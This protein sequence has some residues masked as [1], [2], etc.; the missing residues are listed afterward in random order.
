MVR[1][2][3]LTSFFVFFVCCVFLLGTM[4]SH[5]FNATCDRINDNIEDMKWH[6]EIIHQ[7]LP[8][9]YPQNPIVQAPCVE[10]FPEEVATQLVSKTCPPLKDMCDVINESQVSEGFK[11]VGQ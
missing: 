3:Y 8:K 7:F 6:I 9:L 5:N 11:D 10:S 2:F 4:A 1:H